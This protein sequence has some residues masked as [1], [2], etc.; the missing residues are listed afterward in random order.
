MPDTLNGHSTIES[1]QTPHEVGNSY[2]T[3]FTDKEVKAQQFE[4]T[5]PKPKSGNAESSD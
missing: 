4:I 1:S 3:H 2:C 5:C